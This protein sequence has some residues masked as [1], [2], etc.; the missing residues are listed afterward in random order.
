MKTY[1]PGGG[2]SDAY[3][4]LDRLVGALGRGD[5]E[6]A[7][8]CFAP[9]ATLVVSGS[10]HDYAS[11]APATVI[12]RLLRSFME[13]SWTPSLRR[14]VG[15][16]RVEEG[17]LAAT[18]IGP[19]LGSDPT[20]DR[21]VANLRISSSLAADGR[22]ETLSVWGS[23]EAVLGQLGVLVGAAGVADTLVATARERLS[24]GVRD[25]TPEEIAAFP[26]PPPPRLDAD[27]SAPAP[28]RPIPP[29]LAVGDRS[30]RQIVLWSVSTLAL[31]GLLVGVIQ[32][33]LRF[34]PGA[35]AVAGAIAI[36]VVPPTTK[37]T[38]IPTIPPIIK[39]STQQGVAKLGTGANPLDQVIVLNTSTNAGL[40][41]VGPNVQ[42]DYDSAVITPA[43]LQDIQG[44]S[45]AIV[46]RGLSGAIFIHGYTDNLGTKEHGLV[47]SAQRADAVAQLLQDRLR[48]HPVRL[49]IAGYGEEDPVADNANPA[50]QP[51]NRRVMVLYKPPAAP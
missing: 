48:G 34:L 50:T 41:L 18:H 5:R 22:L 10:H 9:G 28:H 37:P 4:V 15:G 44:L 29:A 1:T 39:E 13:V 17:V 23:R 14:V 47:L 35:D 21:V 36:S 3:G 8:E 49:V 38:V 42:F 43:A 16:A 24:T 11:Y 33:T 45:D 40:A 19:F 30:R 6:A 25:Y 12:D 7:L 20:G 26:V 51:L 27:P 31:L 32:V 46:S 2:M